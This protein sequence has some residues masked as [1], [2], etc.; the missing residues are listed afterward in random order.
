M[1]INFSLQMAKNKVVPNLEKISPAKQTPHPGLLTMKDV[2]SK[3]KSNDD[4]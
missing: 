4:H 2:Q 3:T 1:L